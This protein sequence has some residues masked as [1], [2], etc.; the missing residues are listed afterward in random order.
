MLP[1]G[2]ECAIPFVSALFVALLDH[3]RKSCHHAAQPTALVGGNYCR[4]STLAGSLMRSFSSTIR[5]PGFFY[6]VWAILPGRI[7]VLD[8]RR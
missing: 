1:H 6:R 7:S 4:Y 8:G 2:S 5:S 3:Q